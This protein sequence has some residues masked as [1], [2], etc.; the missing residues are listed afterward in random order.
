M[1][2]VI[3]VRCTSKK[4]V[5]IPG[6]KCFVYEFFVLG[7]HDGGVEQFPNGQ[8]AITVMGTETEFLLGGICDME[9]RSA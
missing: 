2:P 1:N 6:V 3:K 5:F 7:A 9:I 8:M 4:E